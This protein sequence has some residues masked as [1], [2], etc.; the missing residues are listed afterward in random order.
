MTAYTVTLG[1][2]Q[3]WS[4]PG[5]APAELTTKSNAADVVGLLYLNG[6]W[7]VVPPVPKKP[8]A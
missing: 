4:R 3:S 5:A 8:D 2:T 7:H 1:K 6:S